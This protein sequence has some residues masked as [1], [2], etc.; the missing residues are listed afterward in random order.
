MR[1]VLRRIAIHGGMTAVVLGIIGLMLVELASIW[2]AANF[3]KRSLDKGSGPD[4]T[5]MRRKLPLAMGFAGFTFVAVGEI[6][7]YYVR[8]NRPAAPE[9]D[10]KPV[11]NTEK[12]LEDL[13][14]QAEA[15]ANNSQAAAASSDQSP[16]NRHAP[17]SQ[18]TS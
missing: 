8:K 10:T 1:P 16:E 5:Q 14:T 17:P 7:L 15:K 2:M 3:T 12:L 13:L 9:P 18:P 4:T 6:V 11:D